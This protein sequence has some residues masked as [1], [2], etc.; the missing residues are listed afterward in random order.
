MSIASTSNSW[1]ICPQPKPRARIRLFCFPYAGGGASIFNLWSNQLPAEIEVCPVQLP[2]RENRL[3]EPLFSRLSPL[4]QTL[5]QVLRPYLDR[6]FALFGHSMGALICFELAHQLRDRYKLNPVHLFVSG[7]RAPGLPNI[8]PL[9]YKLPE[10]DFVEEIRCLNGTPE[11]VI[12][13]AELMKIVLPILRADFALCETYVYSSKN[14]L[15]CPISA[16]GGLDDGEVNYSDLVAWGKQTNSYFAPKMFEG[17]HFFLQ[18]KRSLILSA[19]SHE[20]SRHLPC[21]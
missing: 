15:D 5:A 14:P 3:G 21:K 13:N 9:L 10:V 1:I 19:I 8:E 18:S 16:F 4:V 6:P 7:R 2:G 20:L 17:D 11:S 12:Q